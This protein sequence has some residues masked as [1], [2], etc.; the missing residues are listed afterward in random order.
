MDI[1]LQMSLLQEI[2]SLLDV[3]DETEVETNNLPHYETATCEIN[4]F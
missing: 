1:A 2:C 3:Q 4:L